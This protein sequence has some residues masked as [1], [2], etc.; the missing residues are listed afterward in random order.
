MVTD[1]AKYFPVMG[2]NQITRIDVSDSTN[3]PH[4][5]VIT[6]DNITT[7]ETSLEL[8]P[9]GNGPLNAIFKGVNELQNMVPVLK[10]FQV[11]GQDQGADA[12]AIAYVVLMDL[13]TKCEALGMGTSKDTLFASTAAYI[14]AIVQLDEYNSKIRPAIAAA[15]SAGQDSSPPA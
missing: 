13:S 7:G 15:S 6:Y 8:H 14:N 1:D 3:G 2:N 11:T 9:S 5:A 12:T 10:Y 4:R